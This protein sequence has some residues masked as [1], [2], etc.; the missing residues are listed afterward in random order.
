MNETKKST[1]MGSLKYIFILIGLV[2]VLASYVLVFNKYKPINEDLTSEIEDL[3]DRRDEL[4]NKAKN[5]AAVEANTKENNEKFD[6]ILADFD[7]GLSYQGEIMDIHFLRKTEEDFLK[8]KEDV[9]I[10]S[11]AYTAP[12]D[13]S[14]FSNG[15][16]TKS[17]NYNYSVTSTYDQMKEML[18][19]FRLYSDKR[20]VPN[21]ISFTYD[22]STNNITT[23]FNVNE[24]AISGEGKDVSSTREPE[25]TTGTNNIFY[26]QVL[27]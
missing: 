15:Y 6:E 17:M 18:E 19:Y 24:Y 22:A 10:N 23:A 13:I 1:S 27:G 8:N 26:N 11:L 3:K 9:K 12:T 4:E 25:C 7:G 20:K 21:T 14:T 2:A 5:K 16:V